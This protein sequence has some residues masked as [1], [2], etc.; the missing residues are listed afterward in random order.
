MGFSFKK[1]KKI[2]PGVTLNVSTKSV[3]LRVGGR[4]AGVS[5]NSKTG[6]RV[7]AS[8]PGTGVSVSQRLSGSRSQSKSIGDEQEIEELETQ[9]KADGFFGSLLMLPLAGVAG[10]VCLSL[11]LM[12]LF[13]PYFYIGIVFLLLAF[14]SGFYAWRAF[15]RLFVGKNQ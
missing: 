12:L 4:N 5:V 1:R 3:G 2:L 8:I 11:G 6:A 9:P 14:V 15:Q 10:L 13:G 7:G